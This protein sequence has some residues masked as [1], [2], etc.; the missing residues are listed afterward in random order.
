MQALHC[1]EM[2]IFVEQTAQRNAPEESYRYGQRCENLRSDIQVV[3]CQVT[4]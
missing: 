4:Q 2:L 3:M 1:F